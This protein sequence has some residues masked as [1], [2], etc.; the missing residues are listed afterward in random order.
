MFAEFGALVG[1]TFKNLDAVVGVGIVRSGDIDGKI[2]AH[3]VKTVVNARGGEDA[4]AGVFDTKSFAGGGEI[5]ENPFGGFASV[6][7]EEN[8]DIIPRV[9]DE[10]AD[11]FG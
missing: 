4:G 6:A 10:T 2:K 9:V 1:P 8:S 3:F 5:L 11:D 7:G